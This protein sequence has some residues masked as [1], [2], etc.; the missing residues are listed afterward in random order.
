MEAIPGTAHGLLE[1]VALLVPLG[2][3]PLLGLAA[4]GFLAQNELLQLPPG[5]AWLH[6]GWVWASLAVLGLSLHLGKSSKLTRP[7]AETL[8][9]GESLLALL[10][11][12]SAVYAHPSVGALA[13][14]AAF[15]SSLVSATAVALMLGT[16][17]MLR[18]AF[19]LLI[20]LSPVPLIDGLFELAKAVL[21]LVLALLAV[22]APAWALGFFA[23]SLLFALLMARWMVRTLK[24]GIQSLRGR[25]G[26]V[27]AP[28]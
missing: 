4:L 10:A 26:P 22:L 2:V 17:L 21:T 14:E 8:G 24:R 6:P 16:V 19:D 28:R 23:L 9:T 20:W 25:T 12:F 18:A 11:A 15:G 27:H 1:V 5:L 13:S 7:L 3:S